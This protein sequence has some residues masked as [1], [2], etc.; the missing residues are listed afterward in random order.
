[1]PCDSLNVLMRFG[2]HNYQDGHDHSV[3]GFSD[4][5]CDIGGGGREGWVA[6]VAQSS[7]PTRF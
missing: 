7:K 1:V 4:V 6:V 2:V 3:D 5:E